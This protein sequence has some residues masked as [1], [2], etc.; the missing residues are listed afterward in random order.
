RA[1]PDAVHE[2]GGDGKTVLHCALTPAIAAFLVDHGAD[3][4]ARDV[5][6]NS[7]PLQ[8]LIENEAIARLLVERGATVDIFAAARLG[9]I[10]RAEQ[11]LRQDRELAAARPNRPPFTGPGLHIYG[12]T[13]GFDVTPIDVARKYGHTHVVDLLLARAS[14]RARLVDALWHGDEAR[15]RAELDAEPT[16]LA[17]LGPEDRGLINEAA[18][19]YRPRAVRLMLDFGFDPHVRGAHR[20]TTLDRACFHGYADI[21]AM[22]LECDPDPPLTEQNEFGGTPLDTCIYGS[23][24]G[25]NTGRGQDHV[26][27]LE[28]LLDAG[29]ALDPTIVPTGNDAIDTFLRNRL[30]G[31]RK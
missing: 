6:H 13:L 2:R 28:L 5:D 22:L 23:I 12:W 30:K 9:D 17:A 27:T 29:A 10:A 11:C 24:N 25:W 7:T 8:Y 1:N 26:R 31:E 16:L 19:W 18:W 4:E 20:S 21:V 15:A 14:P 3:L